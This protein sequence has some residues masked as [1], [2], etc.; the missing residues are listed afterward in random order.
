MSERNCPREYRFTGEQ[1][2]T[3][4]ELL[5]KMSD[6]YSI[7]CADLISFCRFLLSGTVF[8]LSPF[9]S[10]FIIRPTYIIIP[11]YQFK[12]FSF[13][14]FYGILSAARPS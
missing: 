5:E 14:T 13:E 8:L 6:S 3:F 4:F 12:M 9:C 10:P 7:F 1:N 2:L 11:S